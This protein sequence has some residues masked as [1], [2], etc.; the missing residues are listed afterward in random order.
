MFSNVIRDY[1]IH[2]QL[3]SSFIPQLCCVESM[4]INNE[5]SEKGKYR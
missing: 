1:L 4:L 5:T 2:T 3:W